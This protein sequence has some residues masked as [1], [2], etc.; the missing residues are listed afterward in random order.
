MR[1]GYSP[2][3]DLMAQLEA[4]VAVAESGSFTRGAEVRGVPQPVVSRRVAAL[5]KRL[6]GRLLSRT[7]RSVELTPL[8]STLLPHAIDLAA[9]VEHLL[10]V[11]A[12]HAAEFVIGTPPDT[13]ARALVAARRAADEGG[14]AL[15]FWESSRSERADALAAGRIRAAFLPSP[16]D[17]AQMS[18]IL[19]AGTAGAAL[20]G[21]RVHVDQLRRRGST[22]RA[23]T[24]YLDAED[25]VPWVRDVIV[26]AA[27]SAGLRTDQI[28]VGASRTTALTA[29]Y[30]YDD[31]IACTASWAAQHDLRWRELGGIDV[32]RSY[33][34]V[35]PPGTHLP[36]VIGRA[37]PAL[38]RA[39]GL[40]PTRE[41]A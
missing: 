36:A 7:S 27:R 22:E 10:D 21:R 17:E 13:D 23:G 38:A 28:V 2:S 34:I 41:L 25:D 35:G 40:E 26:R 29:A 14:L 15:G 20:R 30:E 33:A 1:F 31:V 24:L 11:A 8:G 18:A 39:V 12:S 6:G 9:R 37:I 16:P 3:V 4:F 5:E 32:Q 19:G